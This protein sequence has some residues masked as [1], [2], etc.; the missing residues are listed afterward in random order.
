MECGKSFFLWHTFYSTGLLGLD[1]IPR[2]QPKKLTIGLFVE[3]LQR[4]LVSAWIGRG[5]GGG[6]EDSAVEWLRFIQ[7]LLLLLLAARTAGTGHQSPGVGTRCPCFWCTGLLLLEAAVTWSWEARS[8][9]AASFSCSHSLKP[10]SEVCQERQQGREMVEFWCFLV[11]V[12]L[13]F[14]FLSKVALLLPLM[15]NS[16]FNFA[17]IFQKDFFKQFLHLTIKQ[18]FFNPYIGD[19]FL[20]KSWFF[21]KQAFSCSFYI[22]CLTR[23]SVSVA[24]LTLLKIF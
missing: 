5:W 1:K 19:L 18:K 12:V 2:R 16:L 14:D 21:Y 20:W 10:R 13:L 9:Q 3:R 8:S 11:S 24:L 23:V 4:P 7:Q 15:L 22:I 6:W 17:A